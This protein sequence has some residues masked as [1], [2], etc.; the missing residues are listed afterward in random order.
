MYTNNFQSFST[1]LLLKM[2]YKILSLSGSK[3][4]S[5]CDTIRYKLSHA[6]TKFTTEVGKK[7][8]K[9]NDFNKLCQYQIQKK[10]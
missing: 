7:S 1:V 5:T 2:V 4:I 9:I 3:I 6:E 8:C 10:R